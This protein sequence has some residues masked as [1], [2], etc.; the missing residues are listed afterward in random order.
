[1]GQ[2]ATLAAFNEG[3]PWLDAALGYLR[4]NRDHLISRLH[5]E[6]PQVRG[7]APEGTYLV[8][9][10]FRAT[11]LGENPA[12][13]LREQGRVALNAGIDYGTG[14][15]GFARINVATSREVLDAAIDRMLATLKRV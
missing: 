7:Y 14:G 10:D 1:M 8:W 13:V 4:A 5:R 3:A 6:A 15:V 12:E 9:L 11:H 2:V